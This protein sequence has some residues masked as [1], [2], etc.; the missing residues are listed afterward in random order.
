[1]I[2]LFWL[3]FPYMNLEFLNFYKTKYL[4]SK[5]NA[6]YSPYIFLNR[7][8]SHKIVSNCPMSPK[9]SPYF[10]S[11]HQNAKSRIKKRRLKN[12]IEY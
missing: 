2:S 8:K 1:M 11:N 10:F 5:K 4:N 7:P 9:I 6:F 3:N 12:P